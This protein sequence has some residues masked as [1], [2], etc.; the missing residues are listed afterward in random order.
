ME[1]FYLA[2]VHLHREGDFEF[3]LRPA[4]KLVGRVIEP[5]PP[6]G[7]VQSGL[8]D[9]ERIRLRHSDLSL[10]FPFENFSFRPYRSASE[11]LQRSF[12]PCC[13]VFF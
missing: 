12:E 10:F 11:S 5:Q 2:I 7:L 9:R 4:E 8:R 6:G 1:D 13:R 3:Q